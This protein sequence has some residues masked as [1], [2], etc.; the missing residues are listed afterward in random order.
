MAKITCEHLKSVLTEKVGAS[1][2]LAV[3]ES[4][5]CGAKFSIVVVSNSFEGVPLLERHRMVNDALKEEM[6]SIHALSMKTWTE[7][8]FD[9]KK[10]LYPDGEALAANLGCNKN[11]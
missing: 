5:G 6:K 11:K 9:G 7:K 4:D 10:H 8:Q 1:I 2:V 3:D